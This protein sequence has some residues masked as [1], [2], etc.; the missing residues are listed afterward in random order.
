MP[1]KFRPEDLTDVQLAFFNCLTD[2]RVANLV[3][4]ADDWADLSPD[5]KDW[6]LKADKKKIDQL[7]GYME[8]M[9][10]AGIIWKFI[11]VGGATAFG[12]FIGITQLWKAFGEFFSVKIK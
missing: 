10:A 2:Q 12:L 7:N 4:A 5:A 11:W 9:A 8:F 1:G 6:L 3:S